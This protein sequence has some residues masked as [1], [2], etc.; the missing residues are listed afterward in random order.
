M[1]MSV[2]EPRS[3]SVTCP[4]GD[5]SCPCPDGDPCHYEGADAFTCPNPVLDIKGL[6]YPHCHV[7][8]CDWHVIDCAQRVSGECGLLKLG[9]PPAVEV[10]GKPFYSM[11]QARPGL[12]GW[13]CGWLRSPGNEASKEAS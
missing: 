9:L 8:G 12:P 5:D 2:P 11:T 7:E 13:A 4:H 6:V 3:I 10:D 1:A